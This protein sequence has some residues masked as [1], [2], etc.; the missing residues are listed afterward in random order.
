M[1]N[2]VIKSK[3]NYRS[4]DPKGLITRH[5]LIDKIMTLTT[6][7]WDNKAKRLKPKMTIAQA[8][9][10]VGITSV[11]Y[12]SWLREDPV[13]EQMVEEVHASHRQMM[14]DMANSI[15]M[16]WL[17]G[18]VK[19]RPSEKISFA[20]RYLEKTS[21]HFNPAQK[22][23]MEANNNNFNMSEEEILNR[24]RELSQETWENFIL[25]TV[26]NQE[27]VNYTEPDITETTTSMEKEVSSG[28]ESEWGTT[29]S[30]D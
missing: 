26:T 7:I 4:V 21:P 30:W 15:I 20:F 24:L 3:S 25:P 14:E 13:L 1:V 6:P 19:L 17:N 29:T 27:D 28:I 11:T 16:E 2:K 18:D 22:I 12:N 9:S 5:S 23:E 10:E 8:C